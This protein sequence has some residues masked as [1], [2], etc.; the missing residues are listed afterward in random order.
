MKF[1]II[2]SFLTITI[3]GL[4]VLVVYQADELSS[5][6]KVLEA[7][8]VELQEAQS[9]LAVKNVE[10]QESHTKY[11]DLES[12]AL[13]LLEKCLNDGTKNSW[14]IAS[15]TNTLSAYSGFVDNCDA[16][17]TDCHADELEAAINKL[18]NE[19]GYVQTVET[20]GNK[21]F[22]SVDLS[23]EGKFIKFKTD[24]S[25]RNGAIGISDCGSSNT[26]RKGVVL[27]DRIVKVLDECEAPGSQSVWAHIQYDR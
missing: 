6:N 14:E 4:F 23:L 26:A 2:V 8:N 13:L 11:L 17:K 20:N 12:D 3:I 21:L 19:N 24:K 7:K 25:V 9:K 27:Q 15:G 1:R 16:I 18:L 5:T 22:T 10:L